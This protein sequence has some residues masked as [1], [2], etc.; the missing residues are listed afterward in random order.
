MKRIYLIGFVFAFCVLTGC[1]SKEAN[2]HFKPAILVDK[3]NQSIVSNVI[4]KQLKLTSFL[5]S[6]TAFLTSS[7]ISIDSPLILING[8]HTDTRTRS[9][10]KVQLLKASETCYLKFGKGDPMVVSGMQC[11]SK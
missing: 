5:M 7:V 8:V 2:N 9:T 6:E 11:I 1:K 3:S 4:E 10:T